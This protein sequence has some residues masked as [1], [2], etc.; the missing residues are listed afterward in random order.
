MDTTLIASP[1]GSGRRRVAILIPSLFGGGAERKALLIAA[2]LHRRGYEVDLLLHRLICHYPDEVPEG[3]RL[4]FSSSRSDVETRESLERMAVT[5]RPL[6]PRPRPWRLRYPWVALAVAARRRQ[7]SLLRHTKTFRPTADVVAYLDREQ[8][9]TLL[10]MLPTAAAVA[11]MAGCLA[12]RPVRIVASLHGSLEH[13]RGRTLRFAHESYPYAHAA[14]GVSRGVA[15]E[16]AGIPGMRPDRIHTIYNPVVSAD[17]TRKAAEPAGHR[18][19]NEPGPPVVLAIGRLHPEKDFPTLLT[20][21]AT[22]LKQRPA[23]LIVLGREVRRGLRSMLLSQTRD[24]R[25]AEHVDF[26]GFVENPYAFLARASL[27]VLSSRSEGLPT[28]LIE[29]MASGCPVVSTDCRFGPREILEEGRWGE[30]VP[31]GDAKT[32]AEAMARTLDTPPARRALRERAAHFDVEG[33][34]DRYEALLFEQEQGQR[35]QYSG[36][37]FGVHGPRHVGSAMPA[38]EQPESRSGHGSRILK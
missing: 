31:V 26:T 2:G 18:W 19:L 13:R 20:A 3:C 11:T 32:L 12:R 7:P 33:A 10:A 8:P 28:V 30:L 29:A 15:G 38:P 34:I 4:F 25:I 27:F 17:L 1:P 37:G 24:L 23:R 36:M 22:L 35:M 16:L 14:V 9:D 21:F 5:P 6:A